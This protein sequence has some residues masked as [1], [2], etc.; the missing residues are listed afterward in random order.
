MFEITFTNIH[1][2]GDKYSYDILFKH[3]IN[4]EIVQNKLT[5]EKNMFFFTNFIQLILLLTF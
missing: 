5:N 1:Y 4:H 3:C 2:Y